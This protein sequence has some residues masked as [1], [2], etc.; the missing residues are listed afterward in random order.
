VKI[1]ETVFR[2]LYIVMFIEESSP[3]HALG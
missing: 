1:W 3:L 2:I